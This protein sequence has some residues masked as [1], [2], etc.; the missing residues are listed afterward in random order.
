MK[1]SK[2]RKKTLALNVALSA[3]SVLT[4]ATLTS[5]DGSPWPRNALESVDQ[6]SSSFDVNKGTAEEGYVSPQQ[7]YDIVSDDWLPYIEN[8]PIDD[9]KTEAGEAHLSADVKKQQPEEGWSPS[10][11]KLYGIAIGDDWSKLRA[12]LGS[13]IDSY[14]MDDEKEKL[15]VLEYTGVTIGITSEHS[16]KF[17]EVYHSRIPTG[18]NGLRIGDSDAAAEKLLGKPTSRSSFMMSYEAGSAMLKLDLDPA[19]SSII[20]MK[21]FAPNA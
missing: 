1:R 3:L 15:A 8:T 21:L 13:P 7:A 10:A 16:V 19:T 2:S 20:A 4:A 11:P 17:V 9:D 14:D 12:L 6:A 18:L 5:C